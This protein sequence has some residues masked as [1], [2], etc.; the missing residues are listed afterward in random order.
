MT[1][2]Y[3][4]LLPNS[5]RVLEL[6]PGSNEEEIECN[7]VNNPLPPNE[8]TAYKALS[9]C[10]GDA[11][12]WV[13]IT[14]NGARL[15]V[16][17]NLHAGLRRLRLE[18]ESRRIWV[19]AV[20]I[21]QDDPVEKSEQ[22][23]IMREIYQQA[24]Q[25]IVWLGEGSEYTA[26][27]FML[28]PRLLNAWK[29]KKET[30]DQRSSQDLDREGRFLYNLPRQYSLEWNDLCNIYDLP[31][32]QRVWIIQEV[33]VSSKVEVLC[34]SHLTSWNN[35]MDAVGACHEFGLEVPYDL[36]NIEQIGLIHAARNHVNANVKWKILDLLVQYRSFR[37]TNLK[38]KVYALLVLVDPENLA[39]SGIVPDYRKEYAVENVYAD[40]LGLSYRRIGIWTY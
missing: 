22:V 2:Q 14:V 11:S 7:L 3:Q 39:G 10:W 19:D 12:D 30:G 29:L 13:P 26:R 27:G 35:L 4:P 6:R 36:S 33:A 38:D 28:I 40:L 37:A 18:S 21:N 16:T 25:T 8:A 23:Q 20:C 31:Y 5:I 1:F 9:Y 32:F 34:G 15:D 17:R 24:S